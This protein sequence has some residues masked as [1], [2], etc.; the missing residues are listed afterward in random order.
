MKKQLRLLFVLVCFSPL[1]FAQINDQVQLKVLEDMDRVDVLIA[2]KLFT[3]YRFESSLEKPVLYPILAPDGTFVTR[4]YPIAPRDKERVDHPHQVGLW[5]NFGDV[6]GYDFWNNSFAIPPE[7]KVHYGRIVH[8]SIEQAVTEGNSG[9]LKV[10]MDWMAPDNEDAERLLEESTTYIFK[11]GEGVRIVDRITTLTAVAPEVRF[12][13]NK[14]GMLALRVD[15]A[16]EM[17]SSEPVVYTDA[18]GKATEVAVM[19]NEGVKGWYLNSEGDEG[20]DAWGKCARW[21]ELTGTKDG[22]SSSLILMD[23][24][25]NINYP[26]CWH[27]R[28]YGLFSVNNLGRQVYNNE[29]DKYQLV[30]NKGESVTFRHRFAVA[31]GILSYS[32]VESLYRDFISE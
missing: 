14:E 7:S 23:H 31:S 10:K 29:L 6:N 18:S 22:A 11:G 17:P 21:V 20:D 5:F 3:T 28:G 26:A 19:D 1:A 13:D 15:R 2:G 9:I 32:D 16:F 25:Q 8:R 30:L 24:P 27:A 12:T 4:G